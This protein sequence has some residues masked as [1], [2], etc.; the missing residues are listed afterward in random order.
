M[1]RGTKALNGALKRID[2]DLR[3]RGIN[4]NGSSAQNDKNV[5]L[6][7]NFSNDEYIDWA[8]TFPDTHPE[9]PS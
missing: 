1:A 9:Q 8:D 5:K 7:D 3:S 4:P 6:S 2:S